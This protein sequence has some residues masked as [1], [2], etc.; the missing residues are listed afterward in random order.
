MSPPALPGPAKPLAPARPFSAAQRALIMFTRRRLV[1]GCQENLRC[2]KPGAHKNV[3][4]SAEPSHH[5]F[6]QSA[7]GGALQALV[8]VVISHGL[9]GRPVPS[10]LLPSW[11]SPAIDATTSRDA[12]SIVPKIVKLGV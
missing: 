9:L 5:V 11:P 8:T 2:L 10:A 7:G 3:R 12:L 4:R 6:R 1:V